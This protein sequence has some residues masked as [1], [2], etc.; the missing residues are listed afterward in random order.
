[1][2]TQTFICLTIAVIFQIALEKP[3]VLILHRKDCALIIPVNTFS[4][5]L[6]LNNIRSLN[7][8]DKMRT[9]D[10]ELFLDLPEKNIE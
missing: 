6:N 8:M 3:S 1:M 7:T 5:E 10:M 4:N 9:E 2:N